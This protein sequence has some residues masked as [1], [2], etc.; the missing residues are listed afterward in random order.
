[1]RLSPNQIEAIVLYMLS[2]QLS[3]ERTLRSTFASG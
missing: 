2:T 1:M 3:A